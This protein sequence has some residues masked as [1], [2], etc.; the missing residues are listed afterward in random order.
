MRTQHGRKF[1]SFLRHEIGDQ[2]AI[3]AGGSRFASKLLKCWERGRPVR[4]FYIKLQQWIEVAEE[5]DRDAGLLTR[6]SNDLED[7][8]N[9]KLLLHSPFGTPLHNRPVTHRIS[10]DTP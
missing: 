2:D 1:A 6:L 7:F 3:D 4:F 8:G 10:Q 9:S 5:N